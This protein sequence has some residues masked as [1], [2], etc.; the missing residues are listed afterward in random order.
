MTDYG[1]YCPLSLSTEVLADRWTPLI[2]RE[3]LLGNTRFND[4]ARGL[5]GISRSM[6][7]QRLRH[8]ERRG[9][10]ELW[11]SPGGRGHEYR[12]TPA[13]QNLMPV[14][15]AMANWAIEWL[16][17]D[18]RP[19]DIEPTQLMWLMYRR[20]DTEQLPH[21][22]VVVEF[23]HTAPTHQRIWMVLDHG[24]PSVC[25]THPGFDSD[26]V[27]SMTTP[28][29]SNVFSG[30]ETWEEAVRS[31]AITV[32][33]PRPIV[34]ALPRWFLWSPF[35]EATRARAVRGLPAAPTVGTLTTR[36][37]SGEQRRTASARTRPPS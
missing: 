30:R 26:V 28:A 29:L 2:V 32:I 35:R 12:L 23:E 25:V 11:P 10:L 34:R 27:V 17:D 4:I 3:L 24:R 20:V 14:I 36:D 8:L 7:T 5:P 22:R 31:G 33:G 9:A 18:L 16:Y 19:E 21:G 13:G 6:L 15:E 37:R 1:N